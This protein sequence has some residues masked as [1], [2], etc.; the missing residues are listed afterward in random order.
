LSQAQNVA[1]AMW[2][3]VPIGIIFGPNRY[4]SLDNDRFDNSPYALVSMMPPIV[5]SLTY[6]RLSLFRLSLCSL[7]VDSYYAIVVRLCVLA[8]CRFQTGSV[9]STPDSDQA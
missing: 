1:S 9:T 7:I 8:I 2:P 3:E 5:L 4:V 6:Y